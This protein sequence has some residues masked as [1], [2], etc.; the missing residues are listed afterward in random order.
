MIYLSK[1]TII[2]ACLEFAAVLMLAYGFYREQ[3]IIRWEQRFAV[4]C[5]KFFYKHFFKNKQEVQKMFIVKK[6]PGCA[7]EYI[8]QIPNNIKAIRAELD[9]ENLEYLLVAG[10]EQKPRVVMAYDAD[11]FAKTLSFNMTDDYAQKIYCG[12]VA[13]VGLDAERKVR[14]LT[15]AEA[16][17]VLRYISEYRVDKGA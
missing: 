13:F 2:Y 10:T 12:P 11:G 1:E 5:K 9:A 16:A 6:E 7:P 8:H 3:D 15:E 17:A 4:K 14:S